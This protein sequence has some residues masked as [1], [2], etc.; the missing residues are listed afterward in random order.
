M[1]SEHIAKDDARKKKT[2]LRES[3]S[4][5]ISKP[6]EPKESPLLNIRS[7]REASSS[8][9]SQKSSR[10]ASPTRKDREAG[11]K[12]KS[13]DREKEREKDKDGTKHERRD[14]KDSKDRHSVVGLEIKF[15]KE[16]LKKAEKTRSKDP[17][18]DMKRNSISITNNTN[19]KSSYSYDESSSSPKDKNI[20]Q[21]SSVQ[22]PKTQR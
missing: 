1:D 17:E 3:S 11:E 15:D 13:K 4:K 18:H 16:K 19:I 20:I 14:S 8:K 22:Y 10:E 6:V 9:D 5:S 2:E 7:T 21:S 12:V